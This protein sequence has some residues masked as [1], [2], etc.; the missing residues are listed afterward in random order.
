M[1]VKSNCF[2][3]FFKCYVP[4]DWI[5]MFGLYCVFE[6]VQ[7]L[8]N[9]LE[10]DS[11]VSLVPCLVFCILFLLPL[12]VV[13]IETS[14]RRVSYSS[15]YNVIWQNRIL[16][17]ALSVT[18]SVKIMRNSKA[19]SLTL[20]RANPTDLMNSSTPVSL[21]P[22]SIS[23]V[24]KASDGFIICSVWLVILDFDSSRGFL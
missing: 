3:V 12:T 5:A 21:I 10:Y 4:G 13:G 18:F 9:L 22:S 16:C 19:V 24:R 2:V 6:F 14:V 1:Y 8:L 17:F 20:V 23:T 7:S 11:T 15:S